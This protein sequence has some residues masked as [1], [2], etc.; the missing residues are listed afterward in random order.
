[1]TVRT[2][3]PA[4]LRSPESIKY[5]S[6]LPQTYSFWPPVNKTEEGLGWIYNAADAI[7]G[8]L[9]PMPKIPAAM[10]TEE[11]F[12]APA[13]FARYSLPNALRE[14]PRFVMAATFGI[15][16]ALVFPVFGCLL[17]TCRCCCGTCGGASDAFEGERDH[18]W[19]CL[20]FFSLGICCA[21]M[22]A[23]AGYAILSDLYMYTGI[24][25]LLPH[26]NRLL[27][28]VETL[29]N[30]TQDE[31]DTLLMKDFSIFEMEMG[32][33]LDS[34]V[35]LIAE[36][37]DKGTS[38][39]VSP[40]LAVEKLISHIAAMKK[41]A[42][43]AR[44]SALHLADNVSRLAEA[45][46]FPTTMSHVLKVSEKCFA[47]VPRPPP[48]E[49]VLDAK[50]L[51]NVQSGYL[52]MASGVLDVLSNYTAQL[53]AIDAAAQKAQVG[54]AA[55][56]PNSKAQFLQAAG[57]SVQQAK[58]YI[59]QLGD[60]LGDEANLFYIDLLE[61]PE[62]LA[63]TV[64]EKLG[65]PYRA[66]EP[67]LA[68][69][70]IVKLGIIGVLIVSMCA[71]VLGLL[72]VAW[73][74]PAGCCNYRSGRWCFSCGACLFVLLFGFIAL[75]AT[76]GL[77]GSILV[78]RCG[79]TLAE[80][81]GQSVLVEP[82]RFFQAVVKE[83]IGGDIL[84]KV[85]T[86]VS[87][88]YMV[89]ALARFDECE[90]TNVSA[91][92]I[93]G[94]PFVRNLSAAFGS[95]KEVAFL[96]EGFNW[97]QLQEELDGIAGPLGGGADD[98]SK[99]QDLAK[100]LSPLLNFSLDIP[101]P[102][103]EP[104][105]STQVRTINTNT[106][107]AE[108][109][110][111]A[112]EDMKPVAA[113]AG[114]EADV[115]SGQTEVDNIILKFQLCTKAKNKV[116]ENLESIEDLVKINGRPADDFKA[117]TIK[118]LGDKKASHDQLNKAN[119]LLEERK[120]SLSVVV[121]GYSDYVIYKIKEDLARCPP[122]YTMYSSSL[123][124]VCSGVVHPFMGFWFCVATYL[125]IGILAMFMALFMST[126]YS[127]KPRPKPPVT[128]PEELFSPPVSP[129][130]FSKPTYSTSMESVATKP[131]KKKRKPKKAPP[132]S[133]SS[134]CSCVYTD[135]PTPEPGPA[136]RKKRF[137]DYY[138]CSPDDDDFNI[139]IKI[140]KAHGH[141]EKPESKIKD[142][143]KPEIE[144]SSSGD[145]FIRYDDGINVEAKKSPKGEREEDKQ[146]EKEERKGKSGT[147]ETQIGMHEDDHLDKTKA[148][149]KKEA[150]A[151]AG[152][153]GNGR[154]ERSQ[155]KELSRKLS[156]AAHGEKMPGL[157]GK[158]A[159]ETKGESSPKMEEDARQSSLD[160]HAERGV[161]G[162]KGGQLK[163]AK[164]SLSLGGHESKESHLDGKKG[165]DNAA[166]APK[167][168]K[169]T[170][171][172]EWGEG[173]DSIQSKHKDKGEKKGNAEEK[174]E[175]TKQK[176]GGS[177]RKKSTTDVR[178][179]LYEP[180]QS[181]VARALR[182]ISQRALPRDLGSSVLNSITNS[183]V[184]LARSLFS[185]YQ[186]V[187]GDSEEEDQSPEPFSP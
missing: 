43:K 35:K 87:A 74:Q 174:G 82:I 124:V 143:A 129:D 47:L 67:Y 80:H 56:V 137:I 45:L 77:L 11:I 66:A 148:M 162:R 175:G 88:E 106:D 183:S 99:L 16:L 91:Y 76:V 8:F 18:V 10:L 134:S 119:A 48:C 113:A 75:G 61:F 120:R 117:E 69:Y 23:A 161:K 185:R 147:N 178:A 115:I 172:K 100:L 138:D 62:V 40:L 105:L 31:I 152:K 89:G 92:R 79:C 167:D 132:S 102:P 51:L 135:T 170:D 144:V 157:D 6:P 111:Q 7:G 17:L 163:K 141:E 59:R 54:Q 52:P 151:A 136:A 166:A 36:D 21:L 187:R 109:L 49:P 78:S 139:Y 142:Q 73:G 125:A 110:K 4:C 24:T 22:T 158:K 28:D 118:T 150:S 15:S 98:A 46:T 94:E 58:D 19:K 29:Y 97:T 50:A 33:R 81:L 55:Q 171:L 2:C 114:L 9:I 90:G 72:V 149:T 116:V 123:V 182:A 34:C 1:M 108:K 154:G 20:C 84:I 83:R 38:G 173:E 60:H 103:S 181:G 146:K 14:F 184:N 112:L 140:M 37:S 186:N 169:H 122:A 27:R 85:S 180:P 164:R 145:I 133:S 44:E 30:K 93:M 71:Y 159:K 165:K 156:S 126:L 176:Q 57:V 160:T 12:T 96:W 5:D 53:T 155:K 130:V 42:E 95:E 177:R 13:D 32:Q 39:A 86:A 153:R 64:Q 107:N 168:K 104:D 128:E 127:R 25:N 101:K 63:Q 70:T 179:L 26:V 3:H 121:K 41:A 131:S 65:K 68:I